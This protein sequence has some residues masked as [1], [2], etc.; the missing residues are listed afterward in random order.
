LPGITNARQIGKCTKRLTREKTKKRKKDRPYKNGVNKKD[1]KQSGVSTFEKV[2][3][4]YKKAN[5]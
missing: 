4:C 5:S 3:K 1:K 2:N